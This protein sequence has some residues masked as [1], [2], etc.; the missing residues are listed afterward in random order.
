MAP[1]KNPLRV[2]ENACTSRVEYRVPFYDTDAMGVVH[3]ANYVRYL[4]LARVRFLQEHD[5]PYVQ[6]VAQGIHVVVTRVEIKLRRATRFDEL[7]AVTGWLERVRYAS[8]SFGYVI[9]CDGELSANATTE[10][11]VVDLQGKLQRMTDAHRERLL[12]LVAR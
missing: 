8:F 1:T 3:H 12:K 5:E 9:D 10:H 6:Y 4:E 7:L 2:P 11:A